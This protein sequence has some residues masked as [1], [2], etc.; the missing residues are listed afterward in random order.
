MDGLDSRREVA[1]LGSLPR[2]RSG[3]QSRASCG[4]HPATLPS[5]GLPSAREAVG[6]QMPSSPEGTARNNAEGKGVQ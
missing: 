6:T 2:T 4:G 1:S 5:R 3:D